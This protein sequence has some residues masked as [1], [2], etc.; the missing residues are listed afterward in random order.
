MP[1]KK[2]KKT[3]LIPNQTIDHFAPVGLKETALIPDA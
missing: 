1:K 2:E 3:T